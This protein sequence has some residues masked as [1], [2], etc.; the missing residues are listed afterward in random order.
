MAAPGPAPTGAPVTNDVTFELTLSR[1]STE[2]TDAPALPSQAR[3]LEL[4]VG[5]TE[6]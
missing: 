4:L 3:P 5:F 2:Y 1:Y 6:A